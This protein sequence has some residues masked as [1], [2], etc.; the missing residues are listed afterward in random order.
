MQISD[1]SMTQVCLHLIDFIDVI[2]FFLTR[3]LFFMIFLSDKK[4]CTICC[5][6]PIFLFWFLVTF[7]NEVMKIT[8]YY[9][10]FVYILQSKMGQTGKKRKENHATKVT[11]IPKTKRQKY[12]MNET[13][14]TRTFLR[15]FV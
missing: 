5:V 1:H 15:I 10:T 8:K 7:G 14:V 11:K 4:L 6:H 3:K 13:K 2:V 9:V 12:G